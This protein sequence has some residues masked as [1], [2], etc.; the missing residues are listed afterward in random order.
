[1]KLQDLAGKYSSKSPFKISPL[2]LAPLRWARLTAL[3]LLI[4]AKLATA[5]LCQSSALPLEE[6]AFGAELLAYLG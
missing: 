5:A 2:L 3:L 1:M 4:S 6:F